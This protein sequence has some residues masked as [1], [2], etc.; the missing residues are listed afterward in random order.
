LTFD[1]LTTYYINLLIMQYITKANA[2]RTVGVVVQEV[3]ANSIIAQ[4][5]DGFDLDAAVGLQLDKLASYRG[6]QR[7]VYGLDLSRDYFAMPY[8]DDPTPEAVSGFSV[9]GEDPAAYW[10]LYAD[11]MRPLYAMTDD[12][13]RRATKYA[14]SAQSRYLSVKEIDD[15]FWLFFGANASLEDN[16]DMTIKYV[17]NPTD[18]DT[19]FKIV[20][21]TGMLPHPAG[22]EVAVI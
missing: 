13:L 16:E 7:T 19:L 21:E 3:T 9:Y 22:V 18:P 1:E 11:V 14:A 10:V 2:R 4:V 8:Y 12:E 15:I 6:V 17:H 20:N 5:R